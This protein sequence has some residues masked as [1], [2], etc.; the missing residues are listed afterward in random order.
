MLEAGVRRRIVS[1]RREDKNMSDMAKVRMLLE[2]AKNL[3]ANEKVIA[4][5]D[6]AISHSWREYVKPRAPLESQKIDERLAKLILEDYKKNPRISCRKLATRYNVNA[7]RVSEL[8][9]GKHELS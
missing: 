6:E 3:T 7:G 2:E 9:S 5:I 4:K 8:V 1:Q